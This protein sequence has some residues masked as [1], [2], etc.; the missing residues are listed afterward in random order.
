[1]NITFPFQKVWFG[2][3]LEE[4]RP[5]NATYGGEPFDLLPVIAIEHLDGNFSY[6]SIEAIVEIDHRTPDYVDKTFKSTQEKDIFKENS[7]WKSKIKTLQD[8]LPA[9]LA[10]PSSLVK[11][12]TAPTAH[13]LIPS[14]TACYFDLPKKITAFNWL[15]ENAYIFHFYRDQQDCLFWY[16]YVRENGESCILASPIPF[17]DDK[18]GQTLTDAIIKRDVFYTASSFEE[19]IYRTWIENLIWFSLED[20]EEISSATQKLCDE[21]INHYK[22]IKNN[23]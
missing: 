7:Q 10:L 1:M 14:C 21:Y 8:S 9:H 15:G 17:E 23:Q 11:F 18:I 4:I 3:D 12:M 16:Y 5:I 19:F 20:D 6:L 2:V 13:G 22:Q